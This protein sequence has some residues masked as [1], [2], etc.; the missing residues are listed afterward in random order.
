MREK[1][2]KSRNTVFCQ[3]F[4]APEDRKVGSL[5]RRVRSQLARW[6]MKNCTPLWREAHFQVKMYKTPQDRTTF[7]SCD[8]EKVHAV[9]ARSTF[10]SQNVK[11]TRGSDHFWKLRCWKSARRCGATHI[12]KSKCTK[13]TMYGPFLEVEKSFRVAG[14]RDCG[15]CQK[16]AKREGFVAFSTTT[17][18]TLHYTPIHY[19]TLQ[20][21]LHFTT[22]H[23]TTLHYT[24]LHYTSPTPTLHYTKLHY[25]TLHYTTLHYTTLPS[26]T[27]HYTTL[28]PTTLHYIT[29]H[30]ITLHY[31]TLHYITLHYT[32]FHYTTLH[33]TT[34][35]YTTLHYTTLH[36]TTLHYTTLH[37]IPRHSTTLHYI[38]LHYITLN[39]TA[40]QIDRYTDRQIDK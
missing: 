23:Y 39:D 28:H 16:W 21:Q 18:T 29:L 3:W 11:S 1:V 12:S 27:L 40:P 30:Y 10:R 4:G 2:G 7:G 26:T 37:Y 8:V 9:V 5:K 20:L 33:Y 36:Y 34:I 6:E 22:L 25:T 32:T 38:T 31:T 17:T 35:H 14:A 13:H 19:T 24:P 15:P